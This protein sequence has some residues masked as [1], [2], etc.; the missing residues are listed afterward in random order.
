MGRSQRIGSLMVAL[1]HRQENRVYLT[2]QQLPWLL[3]KKKQYTLGAN[4][5][6]GYYAKLDT[7][8][9]F[10]LSASGLSTC[11]MIR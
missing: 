8:F 1:V 5:F 4:L 2:V 7:W 11:G 6:E 9:L 3:F 10:V